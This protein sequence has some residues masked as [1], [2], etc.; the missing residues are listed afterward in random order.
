MSSETLSRAGELAKQAATPITDMRG[1]IEYRKHL[2]DV[3]TK[4]A[5]VDAIKRVKGE[6][7]N[8]R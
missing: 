5:L 3:L 8:G 2:T 1:T 6:K 4:R 7:V